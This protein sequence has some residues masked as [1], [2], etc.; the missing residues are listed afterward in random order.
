MSTSILFSTALI[1]FLYLFESILCHQQEFNFDFRSKDIDNVR[2]TLR[3]SRVKVHSMNVGQNTL[4][5]KVLK[6]YFDL[7]HTFI[8]VK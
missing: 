4:L 8:H 6:I 3:G 1:F 7:L 5:I 2:E